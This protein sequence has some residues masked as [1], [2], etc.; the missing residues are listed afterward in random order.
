MQ[1]CPISTESCWYLGSF[2][3]LGYCCLIPW[4]GHK[5]IQTWPRLATGS[6]CLVCCREFST[7]CARCWSLS[8]NLG[9]LC[10][11]FIT[12]KRLLSSTRRAGENLQ[13]TSPEFALRTVRVQQFSSGVAPNQTAT[14]KTTQQKRPLGGLHLVI[15]SE[16]WKSLRM[17]HDE[18]GSREVH[19]LDSALDVIDLLIEWVHL[20]YPI[21][22]NADRPVR[23]TEKAC[24]ARSN[25]Q[26]CVI[27]SVWLIKHGSY[28]LI[29]L[30]HAYP[31]KSSKI[32]ISRG[33][34][35]RKSAA[36][37][38]CPCC[39]TPPLHRRDCCDP[40]DPWPFDGPPGPG[41]HCNGHSV[42]TSEL[43]N[44]KRCP[45]NQGITALRTQIEMQ[46]DAC[47]Q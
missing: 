24:V 4:I 38:T 19:T 2:W 11:L 26:F 9:S 28:C 39:P 8:S 3:S 35:P 16:F 22:Q 42:P 45:W 31:V 1:N 13:E 41:A 36:R 47:M 15:L 30:N 32:R 43:N 5:L 17:K 27:S 46:H 10:W 7:D 44:L 40:A 18:T 29:L 6:K 14:T 12:T 23:V 21:Q 20:Q 37:R 25:Q 33:K 34:I